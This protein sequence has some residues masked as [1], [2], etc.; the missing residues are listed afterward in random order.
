MIPWHSVP[1]VYDRSLR[2]PLSAQGQITLFHKS[3]LHCTNIL[4]FFV[5]SRRTGLYLHRTRLPRRCTERRSCCVKLCAVT[6][7]PRFVLMFR[8]VKKSPVLG[9]GPLC[10]GRSIYTLQP[11][12]TSCPRSSG[13][14][15]PAR[16]GGEKP[17]RLSG[18]YQHK[19]GE[20]PIHPRRRNSFT[21]S[22]AVPPDS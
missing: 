22:F 7:I 12:T 14:V 11:Q 8:R 19:A 6:I 2:Y 17:P 13:L 16:K 21:F 4:R 18:A 9:C 3:C 15:P 5:Q 20:D 1:N 10:S